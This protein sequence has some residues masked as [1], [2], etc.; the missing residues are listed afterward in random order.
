M[1]HF[2]KL[3]LYA[4]R[5]EYLDVFRGRTEVLGDDVFGDSQVEL[6]TR[7]DEVTIDD[8]FIRFTETVRGAI[9]AKVLAHFTCALDAHGATARCAR[10]SEVLQGS[11]GG[12]LSCLHYK[13]Y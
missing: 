11:E 12:K 13:K 10:A 1:P 6:F 9:I 8:D 2:A 5:G 3:V 4:P 7:G